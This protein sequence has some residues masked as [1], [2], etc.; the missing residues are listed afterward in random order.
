M[1]GIAGTIGVACTMIVAPMAG[2]QSTNERRDVAASGQPTATSRDAESLLTRPVTLH[3]SGASLSEAIDAAAASAK[4]VVQYRMSLVARHDKSVTLQVRELPLRV[5]LDQILAGT[6]LRVTTD[7]AARLMIVAETAVDGGTITGVVTDKQTGRP[8]RGASVTLDDTKRGVM[9]DEGGKFRITGV[10]S[11]T[12]R[13]T[14]RL[15]GFSKKVSSVTVSDAETVTA[16]VALEASVNALEQVVVT[17]TV[18]PTELKAVPNAITVIT[19]KDIEQRGITQIQQLFRGDVPGLFSINMGSGTVTDAVTMFSRGGTALGASAGTFNG[20][21]PIKTYVDGVEMADP[22]YL[23]QIDPKSVE[24]IEILTGPQ[25]STI[26]GS[27]AINGV[28]QIFTKRGSAAQPQ[29]TLSLLGGWVQNNY[30]PAY[31]PQYDHTFSVSGVDGHVSYNAGA[32]WNF[33]GAWTPAKQTSHTNVFGGSR[34]TFPTSVGLLTADVSVRQSQT[35]NQRHGTVEETKSALSE[36]GYWSPASAFGFTAD[37]T[38][39]VNGRT[40]GLTLTYA[41]TSWWTHEVRLGQDGEDTEDRGNAPQY[42]TKGDT[43]LRLQQTHTDKRSVAYSTTLRFPLTSFVQATVTA[44][45]DGWKGIANYAL[46]QPSALSG[47]LTGIYPAYVTRQPAHNTGGFVQAQAGFLDHLFLTYGLRAEW[48]PAFG[49]EAEPTSAPR[50]G[51]SYTTDFD[52]PLGGVTAKLRASYGRSTRPPTIDA[53]RGVVQDDPNLLARYGPYDAREGNPDLGPEHQQGG[54]GGLEL[55]FGNRFSLVATRYN[56]TVEG[57]ITEISGA[58]SVR[59]LIPN[60]PPYLGF[61]TCQQIISFNLL[62]WCSSQD[63]QGYWYAQTSQNINAASIRNQ[64]WELQGTLTTGPL[65]TKGTYSWTKSRTIGVTPA[66]L[67]HASQLLQYDPHY[68][69]GATF[70]YL[71]EHTWA[72]GFTYAQA[73]T[74]IS[75]NFT[76]TGRFRDLDNKFFLENLDGSIRLTQNRLNVSDVNGKYMSFNPGDMLVDLTASHRFAQR[77]E[78]VLQVQNLMDRFQEDYT[79]RQALIGRQTKVGVRIRY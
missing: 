74:T 40:L 65:T 54:E 36:S 31:T 34:F 48:N 22:Q 59:S 24:R 44:G 70:D 51:A 62:T 72:L 35:L 61:L 15:I 63:A 9:T 6:G 69:P 49:S 16:N 11:G 77:V 52:T 18:I 30:S 58:D 26:Y 39:T 56:Q 5:A 25:A 79:F 68:R 73:L 29:L 53:K 46:I 10:A 64:G 8:V 60:P 75:A 4:V 27:N 19:A 1:I 50:Y 20:T 57:L 67:A 71:P 55:Y 13:L 66:F 3:L 33:V 21:N 28:M 78:G 76:G 23:S 12:H 17:G 47:T 41:P 37:E 32:G 2:A 45:G 43:L 42:W 14:I 38:N 7:A